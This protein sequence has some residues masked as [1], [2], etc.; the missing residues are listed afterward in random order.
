M[1]KHYSLFDSGLKKNV[2]LKISEELSSITKK[3]CTWDQVE[4]KWKGLKKTYKKV[5]D[6]NS[7]SGNEKRTWEFFKVIDDFMAKRPEIVPPAVCNSTDGL[8]IND[9]NVKKTY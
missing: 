5:K 2:W 9:G 1:E 4:N 8:Q 3:T 6:H 7:K